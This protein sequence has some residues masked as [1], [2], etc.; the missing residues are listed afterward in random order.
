M[1]EW[2]FF[3]V[4]NVL[5]NDD[6]QNFYAYRE[7]HRELQ[8]REPGY[9]FKELLAER[10]EYARQGT[11]W[12]LRRIAERWMTEQ[13]IRAAMSK[14]REHLLP[15]YDRYHLPH[16]GMN[17][18]LQAARKSYRLGVIAN[19][20]AECRASLER[21]GLLGLFDVVAISEE[22][23]LHKPDIRLFEW[24]LEQAGCEPLRAVMVGDRLDNDVAPAQLASMRTVHLCW[25][26]SSGRGWEPQDEQER[27]FLE[28]CDRIPL[29][30]GRGA[31]VQPD[32]RIET[33]S[34]AA[35]A[36]REIDKNYGR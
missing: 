24:A 26:K 12:I 11:K 20:P 34:Q 16:G 2:V 36:V 27:A 5:F 13:E 25:T 4:G 17:D 9:R 32:V 3:D 29:F 30:N 22:L 18:V 31:D 6:R 35:G 15:N 14:M 1:I 21:R 28:S 19:Q 7:L 33:L 8:Q 23:D 10:E